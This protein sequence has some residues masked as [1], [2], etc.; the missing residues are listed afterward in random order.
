MG[1]FD[2]YVSSLKRHWKN[3]IKETKKLFTQ[4]EHPRSG[5]VPAVMD[6]YGPTVKHHLPK[7]EHQ[8]SKD[9]G[10][11]YMGGRFSPQNIFIDRAKRYV[12]NTFPQ[13]DNYEDADPKYLKPTWE[14]FVNAAILDRP[15]EELKEDWYNEDKMDSQRSRGQSVQYHLWRKGANL[16]TRYPHT[17]DIG[18]TY[19]D[20]KGTPEEGR[21]PGMYPT[22]EM[23]P[24]G[25]GD[26]WPVLP[27]VS[28]GPVSMQQGQFKETE[29]PGNKRLVEDLYNFD[30]DKNELGKLKKGI[31]RLGR[32]E[33]INILA[34]RWL[35]ARWLVDD[36]RLFRQV[37]QEAPRDWKGKVEPDHD[38]GWIFTGKKKM[39]FQKSKRQT[40]KYLP[41]R[42][43]IRPVAAEEQHIRDLERYYRKL[44]K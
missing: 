18:E 44:G 21:G 16:P 3:P 40:S 41:P 8:F 33:E 43:L 20:F 1:V 31:K 26:V 22:V 27:N 17:Q 34:S 39:P 11:S 23:A 25:V 32:D 10:G 4:N 15:S 7:A 19:Y 28:G 5:L 14:K 30:L 42:S 13:F 38:T 2:D 36:P 37:Y 6:A 9:F 35:A 24:E 12:V 29:L